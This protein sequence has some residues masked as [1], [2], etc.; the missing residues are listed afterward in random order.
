MLRTWISLM[1][2]E[3]FHVGETETRWS[4]ATKS[5][6]AN[7]T[8]LTILF[9][10][11]N[12]SMKVRRSEQIW[13]GYILIWVRKIIFILSNLKFKVTRK[14]RELWKPIHWNSKQRENILNFNITSP[15]FLLIRK[16]YFNWMATLRTLEFT[17]S[18]EITRCSSRWFINHK[19]TQNL[20]LLDLKKVTYVQPIPLSLNI[21]SDNRNYCVHVSRFR[22][23][24]LNW[25]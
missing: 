9:S 25:S 16:K 2:Q 11:D 13:A 8:L 21:K 23:M 20:E 10:I 24:Q 6:M 17:T 12:S 19:I 5:H 7:H 3:G 15:F 22:M 14:K 4:G 1:L 18:D